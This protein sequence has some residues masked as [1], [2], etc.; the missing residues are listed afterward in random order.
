LKADAGPETERRAL[1]FQ[2]ALLKKNYRKPAQFD[3]ILGYFR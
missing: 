1:D 3:S 2:A